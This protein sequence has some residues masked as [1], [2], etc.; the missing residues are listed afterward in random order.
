M[1]EIT[2]IL[3][4]EDHIHDYE[5]ARREILKSVHPCEFKRVEAQ[6]DYLAALDAFK[7]DIILSD[8]YL[9][10][11]D[12]MNAL[13]LA[14][15]HSPFTPLIIWTGS[16]SEDTAV[17]C[18]KAGA[19]NYVLKDNIKRL[20]TAVLHALEERQVLIEKNLADQKLV[21]NEKR[22]R[23]LIENA[24]DN[25][26]LLTKDGILLWENQSFNTILGYQHDEFLARNIFEL[27]HP[28]DMAWTQELFQKVVQVP[29]N[30]QRGIFRLRHNDGSWKW[31]EAKATNMLDEP[32]VGAVVINYRDITPQKQAD[33]TLREERNLLRTLIDNLPD[34]VYVMDA[35]GRKTL[36]NTADWMSSGAKT[37]E[38][39]IGKTDFETYPPELAEPFWQLDK[40]VLESGQPVINFEEPGL[41]PNG[42][43]VSILTTKIPLRNQ[44]DHVIGLV[45][46]GRDIT[47]RKRTEVERQTLLE[48]MQGLAQ[49][50]DLNE[51][52]KLLHTAIGRVI[53]AEN[54]FVVLHDPATGLFEE[55][56]TVDRFDPPAPPSRLEKSITSYVYRSGEPLLLN[57][58]LFNE[59]AERGEVELIGTNSAS[60]LGVPLKTSSGTIGVIAVQDYEN[61]NRYSEHDK[62]FLASIASQIAL[63]VERKR[64][65][66]ELSTAREFLQGVQNSLSA[67]IAILDEHGTVIQVN[68]AWQNF[69]EQNGWKDHGNYVGM[70]YLDI[71]ESVIGPDADVAQQ[72]VTTIRE[73]SAGKK[74]EASVEYACHSPQEKRWFVVHITCFDDGEH[75]WTI[76][77]HEN[78]TPRVMA[79]LAQMESSAQ[80]HTLFEASP[81]AIMLID[82]H[83]EW[84]IVDCNSAACVMNGYSREELIGKPIDII[85]AE[86]DSLESRQEYLRKIRSSGV[87]RY[88]TIHVHKDGTSFP[89]EVST[90]LIQ[91]GERTMVLGI[92]RDITERKHAESAEREQ[93]TLAEALRDTAET[94]NSTLEYGDVLDHILAAVGR[95][96]PHDAA[97]IMLIDGEYTRVVREHGYER[98]GFGDEIMSVELRTAETKNL[99]K[100]LET[101][102]P[103]I[104]SDTHSFDGWKMLSV[105]DRLRSNVG[106]PISIYGE[107]IGFI[108]LDSE[109]VG[110]FTPIHAE[111][112]KAFA[113]QAAIAIQNAR[114]LQQAQK[115]IAERKLVE[116]ALRE[117]EQRYR[118]IFENS[119][120]SIWEADFSYV[121][122]HIDSLKKQGVTDFHTYFDSH[123]EIVEEFSRMITVLDVNNAGIQMY[124]ATSK[125]ELLDG[126]NGD[127]SQGEREHNRNDFIAIAEGKTSNSWDGTDET[128][129]HEPLEISVKWSVAPG[130]EQDFSKV[131]ITVTDITE[132]KRAE[133]ELRVSEER[134][135]QLATNI[136]E[137]FWITDAETGKDLYFSPAIEGIW[138]RSDEYMVNTPNAFLNSIVA[139]DLPLVIAN[140]EK[141]K[142]GEKTEMEYRIMRPDGSIRW[143][144]DRAFPIFDGPSH[145]VRVT[146]IVADITERKHA[147]EALRESE[148]RFGSAFEF[149]PIGVALVSLDGK[150]VKVNQALCQ[151]LGYTTQELMTKTFQELTHPDDLEMDLDNVKQLI[152]GEKLAYQMEKRYFDKSGDIVW[153]LLSVSL[154]KDAEGKP[155]YFISQVQDVTQRKQSDMEIQRYLTELQVL[156][157]NGLAVGKLLEPREVGEH[158]IHTFA[159]YLSWH[160]VTIRLIDPETNELNLIAYNMP[161]LGEQEKAEVERQFKTMV[162]KVGQGLS[163]WTAQTGMPLRTGHVHE[164][165]QYV[166]TQSGIES[167]LY[168]PL[169]VG[170][171]VIGVISVESEILDAF[172]EQDERLL[173]TLA[174][175]AAIAFEN[176]RL[177]QSAQQEISER[178]RAQEA[179]WLSEAH[180]RELADSIT[181]ILFELDHNL[182]YTHWNKASE[183][184]S[185]IPAEDAIGKSMV[186]VWGPSEDLIRREDIYRAVLKNRQATTFEIE[187]I[188]KGQKR[189]LEINAY[190]SAR[191]VSVV[192][193]DVTDRK[194][195]EI[196]MHKRLELIDYSTDHALQ[197]VLQ[198]VINH[199]EALTESHIG[200]LH[201]I[202]A[203]EMTIQL[204]AWS[205]ETLREFCKAEGEGMHYPVEQA[206]AWADAIRQQRSVIH[207]DFESL[208]GRKGL[209]EG[210]AP[211]IREMVVPITRNEKVVALIGV[212]NKAQEYSQHDLDI[213][214][215]FAD[216]AWDILERKQMESALADERNQLAR[217]VEERTADLSRANSNLARALRVKDE[218]LANMSHELRT[219]LNAILG[220]SESLS[221]QVAGPLNEKQQKYLS[222]INESGH[223]LLSLINDILDLAK[224]EAGQITLD[225]NKVDLNSVCQA[226]LRMIKQ[227]AQRKEQEVHFKIDSDIGLMWAD[228]RRLKQMIVNLLSNAVKFTPESGQLGLDVHGDRAGNKVII[229][230]WDQGIGISDEDMK[231]LFKPFVQLDSGLAREATGTG[232]GLALVAQMA[233]LHGGSVTV[234]SE[235]G[236]GSRFTILL[237]WEPALAGDASTR[238][239]STGKF[240]AVKPG[241][242]RPTILLIE[243]TTEVVMMLVDYLEMSGF[244]MVT[245]Q[246]GVDGL[247]QAKLSHPDLILMDIQ[248]P[249]MDGF[250]TTKRLRS[251]PEFMDTPII[252]LTALA[253]PNDRERCL[254][255]GMN[256]YMSKPVNLKSLVKTIKS[257]LYDTEADRS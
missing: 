101:G 234:E 218:F 249:R 145:I 119:P 193:K 223:H 177:Y 125:T 18:M 232:L 148:A 160:H 169:K 115:E 151:L 68:K 118:T 72:V 21:E 206:G 48:I 45:G 139:D 51:F 155:Q 153:A 174:N 250:E 142:R 241:E 17:D 182:H 171:K 226:S 244:N 37:M 116:K 87:L 73:V 201:L 161:G 102:Q 256:E 197:D 13:K 60:W 239:R 129:N 80:F 56:Y 97:T 202:D 95:V 41:D 195:D 159:Q 106:A 16:I 209:P 164:H 94:L 243:D 83:D 180:Y 210:H 212:G 15:E 19:S 178:R 247:T 196:L 65:D 81:D 236:K 165:P 140:M 10:H 49:T 4:V 192:A 186:E 31:I 190:P 123:P 215:R 23:A 27:M 40:T 252:A 204:Q 114:L 14:R 88:E 69:G 184:F 84:T 198:Q 67:H 221:E 176:A 89:I 217:R 233:R 167:G 39:V 96:V 205:T 133:Q 135:R 188:I 35:E 207:N 194:L 253:M 225:I 128:M 20:G 237:P 110:F 144:W 152:A 63:A 172:T 111:R 219:P 157:E 59:L 245:A 211:V 11:F 150:L 254:E 149:A 158:I 98:L 77:A 91:L 143:I 228:E 108:L 70:N 181:D 52:V 175:Q 163:G 200:F 28:D 141:Q 230:V 43:L 105:T 222:T 82:P 34:R 170:E 191:G 147:E 166:T 100:I 47:E 179:L 93:R 214:E 1:N 36:S 22:F 121:K 66:K 74:E 220:L 7:P 38:E 3:I 29:G 62:D 32:S 2:R 208:P 54:F 90:S 30:Q 203:E 131:Y 25:I 183:M 112:L 162:S 104:I 187:T 103:V 227:L 75:K 134:F 199:A 33:E 255:V 130:Y 24:M 107:S 242:S 189:F 50:K 138:G 57:Q 86:H 113:N 136:E 251:D 85:N 156:Y 137:A 5:L 26:S 64:A 168:M 224:I 132:R 216:Y 46:I 238:L 53:Y 109:T 185:G 213:V 126:T 229:S 127:F 154:V 61:P 235:T 76:L 78:I 173:A 246:D 99:Q 92:D 9:P 55:I 71:C 146:G 12:G 120:V 44:E 117:S 124:H 240:Q 8:Y 42:N 248:M 6:T 58:N 79:E 122:E 231:R 257:Y